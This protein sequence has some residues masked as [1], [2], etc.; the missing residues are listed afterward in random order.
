[1]YQNEWK[2]GNPLEENMCN[3]HIEY[4]HFLKSQ[5]SCLCLCLPFLL[6]LLVLFLWLLRVVYLP[7]VG[8][9][10]SHTHAIGT[11]FKE[12][13][14][15]SFYSTVE[16]SKL[17]AY[18]AEMSRTKNNPTLFAISFSR[19]PGK[20]DYTSW[21]SCFESVE[22][23]SQQ[24][25][26]IQYLALHFRHSTSSTFFLSKPWV[27]SASSWQNLGIENI[28]W[29]F[30]IRK[31]AVVDFWAARSNKLAMSLVVC[32]SKLL[33]ILAHVLVWGVKLWHWV[34]PK[35]CKWTA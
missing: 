23:C 8:I 35:M 28:D 32:T 29:I 10:R 34:I 27:G 3:Y 30:Q 2:K 16:T 26:M 31:P 11:R 7:G 25:K 24:C 15:N 4:L 18:S 17:P 19:D 13:F 5:S 20:S 33:S 12:H 9:T 14:P 21:Y 1:M 22:S 6:L